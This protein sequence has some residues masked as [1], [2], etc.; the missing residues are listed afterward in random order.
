MAVWRRQSAQRQRW[1]QLS[2][3]DLRFLVQ[4]VA[5]QRNDHERVVELLRDKPDIVDRM[6]DDEQL[7]RRLLHE[8]EALV[9]ASPYLLFTVLLRR[10]ARDL[11]HEKFTI[12]RL[13]SGERLPVFDASR[14]GDLLGDP[15][16][17]DYLAEMLTS[18]V[19][20]ESAT[21]YYR[22]GRRYR[23][24]T[25]SDMDVD[26]MI[27]LAGAAA[28]EFRYPYYKRIGDICLFITGV[29]PEHVPAAY[30]PAVTT[31]QAGWWRR[32]QR[33]GLEEYELEAKRFYK[34]AAVTPTA[35]EQGVNV[36]LLKLAQNF[37]LARKPLNY[38][39]DNYIRLHRAQ[40][41]GGPD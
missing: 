21:V 37:N 20:T 35:G 41:F 17:V 29:F 13:G 40:L 9:R 27:A 34:L 31:P 33:R 25:Y 10:A 18:F 15:A 26:D 6:L 3:S 2:E 32:R 19:R 28:A 39:T 7:F 5:T 38:I 22:S 23:R 36:T 8:E 4:T 24:R 11:P 14:V 30:A 16:V 1:P 12:E